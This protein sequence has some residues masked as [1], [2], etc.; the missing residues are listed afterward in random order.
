MN[1]STGFLSY[2]GGKVRLAPQIVAH[3]GDHRFYVEPFCGMAAVLFAKS[4]SFFELLNDRDDYLVTMLRVVRERPDELAAALSMTPY[5]RTEYDLADPETAEDE[6]EV[7]RRV[8]VRV[9]QSFAK[10]GLAEPSKGWRVSL[11]GGRACADTWSDVPERV[12]AA[13]ERLRGV[14]IDNRDALDII[15]RYGCEPE[16][17]IYVDPPYLGATRSQKIYRHEL[18]T[19]QEHAALAE[20]LRGCAAHV[21]LSGYHSPLYDDLY[22][23]WHRAEYAAQANNNG[24]A[25]ADQSRVEVLWSN[26]PLRHAGSLFDSIE[27]AA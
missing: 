21:L 20:A 7:A 27:V 26:R 8:C 15:D 10:A 16:A 17:L 1:R 19:E 6:L 18:R 9:G 14:H 4:R 13:A 23:G 24:M 11:R 2:P 25:G 22:G 3:M 12:L 5:A